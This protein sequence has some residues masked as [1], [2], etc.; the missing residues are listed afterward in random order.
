MTT[1]KIYLALTFGMLLWGIN[2]VPVKIMVNSFPPA[3][4]T[5]IRLMLAGFFVYLL[6]WRSEPFRRLTAHEWFYLLVATALGVSLH[7][8]LLAFGLTQTAATNGS[9]ILALN[10]LTTVL[11]SFLFLKEKLTRLRSIGIISGFIGVSIT[12]LQGSDSLIPTVHL[13]DFYVF[14][15]MLTQSL[16]FLAVRQVAIS[17]PVNQITAYTLFLGGVSLAIVGPIF[18]GGTTIIG[19]ASQISLGMWLLIIASG[20]LSTALG[21]MI[22]NRGIQ[23]LGPGQAAIFINM[24]P[25]YGL[26]GAAVFLGETIRLAHVFGF[27]FIVIGVFL[28]SGWFELNRAKR[29]NQKQ[30]KGVPVA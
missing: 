17:V 11:L 15:A 7:Q 14:L 5:A 18:D 23:E 1:R 27:V 3:G 28:G 22:W 2:I 20:L 10:P 16:S 21:G 24:T 4:V 19:I 9:L 29:L 30:R 26:L 25:F 8:F 12:I 13:G 6:S